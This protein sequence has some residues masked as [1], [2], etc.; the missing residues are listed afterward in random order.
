MTTIQ[1]LI[2]I[3]EAHRLRARNL[4]IQNAIFKASTNL[5]WDRYIYYI[6]ADTSLAPAVFHVFSL[7]P[8]IVS[9]TVLLLQSLLLAH[10]TFKVQATSP[11]ASVSFLTRNLIQGEL[12]VMVGLITDAQQR[13]VEILELFGSATVYRPSLLI[14]ERKGVRSPRPHQT[15]FMVVLDFTRP[16]LGSVCKHYVLCVVFHNGALRLERLRRRRG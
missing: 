9:L 2:T 5:F 7:P 8:E 1:R 10:G 12:G 3:L 6:Y 16:E 13:T 15:D 11:R 14:K 4:H